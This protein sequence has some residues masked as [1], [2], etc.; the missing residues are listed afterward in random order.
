MKSKV[1]I[2]MLTVD[3]AAAFVEHLVRNLPTPGVRAAPISDPFPKSHN[4]DVPERI[5]SAQKRWVTPVDT[6]GWSR[7]WGAFA[8]GRVVGEITLSTS[9]LIETQLHRAI[10]GM[11]IEPEFRGTGIGADL[12]VTALNWA[13]EQQTLAWIDLGVF[14]HNTAARRLYGNFGFMEIGR[15]ID[16][17]RVDDLRVDDI[18]MTLELSQ[19]VSR[20]QN[21]SR[22]VSVQLEPHD[23][24]WKIGFLRMKS[25]M[26][27][28][29]GALLKQVE[30]FGSTSIPGIAAK[31]VI[32]MI[33]LVTSLSE[34][35]QKISLGLP[36]VITCLGENGVAGRRYLVLDIPGEKRAHMHLFEDGHPEYTDRILFRDFLRENFDVAKEYETLKQKLCVAHGDDPVAYWMGK[37]SF[38]KSTLARAKLRSI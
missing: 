3:D 31:P 5:E 9:R 22:K 6:L 10:L 14:A 2:R 34:L 21:N 11:G 18:Q 27:E 32:D 24:N 35:D 29:F 4:L 26:E 16:C 1:L 8:D 20:D 37:Q 19:Y 17:F 33:G 36:K 7:A 38:V 12:L 15:C 13:K 30:H 25:M 28:V 23:A